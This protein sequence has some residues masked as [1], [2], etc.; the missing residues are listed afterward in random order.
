MPM[1][2]RQQK[3]TSSAALGPKGTQPE[4]PH[5]GR[6]FYYTENNEIMSIEEFFRVYKELEIFRKSQDKVLL[7]QRVDEKRKKN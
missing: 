3:V 4:T 2:K 6:P 5:D 1:W 7:K